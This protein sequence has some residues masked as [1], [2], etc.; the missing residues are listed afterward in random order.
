MVP[1]QDKTDL[2]LG[3]L[4]KSSQKKG[5]KF[6]SLAEIAFPNRLSKS[7]TLTLTDVEIRNPV[8]T[9]LRHKEKKG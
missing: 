2:K 9:M 5:L 1:E 8:V 3:L 7:L 4:F 6:Q